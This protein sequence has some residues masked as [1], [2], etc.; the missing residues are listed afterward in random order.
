MV[1]EL[2]KRWHGTELCGVKSSEGPRLLQPFYKGWYHND[3]DPASD[4]ITYLSKQL[5]GT[6]FRGLL[7]NIFRDLKPD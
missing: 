6:F 4:T 3:Q 2:V 5:N 7:K 1:I